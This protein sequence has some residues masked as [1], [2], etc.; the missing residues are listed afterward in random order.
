MQLQTFKA[1]TMAEALTQVKAAMGSDAIILHTRTF[2]V[3][4]MLGL[5][6]KE[7]VEITAGKG[8]NIGTR[9]R[10]NAEGKPPANV[11]FADPEAPPAPAA[12]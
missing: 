2:Q 11:K 9:R 7:M 3:R 10:P 4:R 1:P 12:R 6:R 5:R 8:M